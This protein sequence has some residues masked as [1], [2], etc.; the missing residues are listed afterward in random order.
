MGP[1]W[2]LHRHSFLLE[3]ELKAAFDICRLREFRVMAHATNPTAVKN[4]IRLGAHSV[5]HG[6]IMDDE[7]IDLMLKRSVWYVPTLAISHLTP[8]QVD[9]DWERAWVKQ[10]NMAQSFCCRADAASDE[11]ATWFRTALNAGVRMALGSDIRPLKDAALL[12]MGLWVK[13]GATPWQTLLAATIN[14]AHVC[15][16]ADDLGT[17]EVGKTGRSHRSR[18]QSAGRHQ[19][20][21]QAQARVQRRPHRLGQ[22]DVKRYGRSA[23]HINCAGSIAL[24]AGVVAPVTA[25]EPDY[26]VKQIRFVVANLAGGTSD[27]L[28]RG[29]RCETFRKLESSR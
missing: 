10:R 11:H 2:D 27:I 18:R 16:A 25:T 14:A 21:A 22:T 28:A 19:Q 17:I 13:D 7:C 12:E 5:E 6:Y 20:R 24:L 1:P 9:N 23:M 29:S 8:E 4:A 3:D 26:P 15:G